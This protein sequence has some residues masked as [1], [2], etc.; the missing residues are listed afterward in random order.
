MNCGRPNSGGEMCFCSLLKRLEILAVIVLIWSPS[1][2]SSVLS[3]K[4]AS[5]PAAGCRVETRD[6]N[7]WKA[8]QLSNEWVTLTIV[9]QLGGRL[10]QVTFA[11]H[12]FLFVN[13]QYKGKHFPPLLPGAKP[14][15]YNYGGD[16]IWPM[17][18][19]S[20]D[21]QHWPGPIAD[22]LDDG[23][24]ALKILSQDSRCN[25]WLD[26]PPDPRTGLQYSRKISIG[27]DSAEISFH[28]VMKNAATHPIRWSMQSVTQYDTSD[29]RSPA[30]YNH[31]FWA[32]TPINTRSA[33]VEGFH[34]R[35]GLADDPSFA[36]KDNLFA[37][38]WLYL[39]S[40]VWLDS[41]GEWL[42]V[43]DKSAHFAMVERFHYQ[44]AG[45]YPGKATVIFY[46]NG[47]A[48]DMDAKGMPFIRTNA[49]DAPF[50]MEA[51]INSPIVRLE[52]GETYAMDTRWYPA[53]ASDQ[54]H[55]ATEA[56]VITRPFSVTTTA[57]GIALSGS[58]GVFYPGQI[59]ACFYN[60]NG[61]EVGIVPLMPASPIELIDL[62]QQ[63][64]ILPAAT[65]ISIRLSDRNGVDRGSLGEAN[66]TFPSGVS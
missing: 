13:P 7:G 53:R 49:D 17:P 52:P 41:P 60:V 50:Y 21:D 18:E 57:N 38:H 65:R 44:Q 24:Y 10:M 43:V 23:D 58:F 40:E 26:G 11:G 64:K 42:A 51:E 4:F 45:E 32:F 61:A 36:V 5:T 29:P 31:D 59:S 62:N 47:P 15:W 66:I 37:L 20:Q 46:K 6:F 56:G 25:V 8:E 39:Q 2:S 28:A 16:K 9:P 55:T 27:G 63:V 1:L 30:T 35:S 14:A 22:S 12:P 19:G 48:V 3:A 54:F 34:V 33:Y